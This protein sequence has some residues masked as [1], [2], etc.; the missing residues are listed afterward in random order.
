MFEI[1]MLIGKLSPQPVLSGET[2]L[3]VNGSFANKWGEWFPK[4]I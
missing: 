3:M 2:M 4:A 1:K